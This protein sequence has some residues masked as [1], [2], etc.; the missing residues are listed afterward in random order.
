M[1]DRIDYTTSDDL[2]YPVAAWGSRASRHTGDVLSGGRP[3]D[4]PGS[5]IERF[6]D[7]PGLVGASPDGGPDALEAYESGQDDGQII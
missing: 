2:T 5:M 4:A 7:K 6:E 1:N 3:E